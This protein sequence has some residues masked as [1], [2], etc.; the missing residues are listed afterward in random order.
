MLFREC[1]VVVSIFHGHGCVGQVVL[2]RPYLERSYII[3]A[4]HAI[5]RA[6]FLELMILAK[7]HNVSVV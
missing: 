2:T 6:L 7:M 5:V 4:D 3:S 1:S